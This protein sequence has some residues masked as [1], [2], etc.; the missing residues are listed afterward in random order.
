MLRAIAHILWIQKTEK[1]TIETLTNNTN[2]L[3][4]QNLTL[5]KKNYEDAFK[6]KI[7]QSDEV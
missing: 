1:I 3:N 7:K 5:N 4:A 6:C 2:K